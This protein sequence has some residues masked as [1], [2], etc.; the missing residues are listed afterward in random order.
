MGYGSVPPPPPGSVAAAYPVPVA[1]SR[2][3]KRLMWIILSA[4]LGAVVL[5]VMFV[6]AILFVVFGSLKSSTPYQHGVQ[7]ATHDPR[8]LVELGAPV[9]PGY[10][11]SGSINVAG[12]TGNADLT[13]PLEGT[14]HKG[15][16][17]VVAKKFEGEWTYQTLAVR[18]GDD[19]ERID[20]LQPAGASSEE[21]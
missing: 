13:I 19:T 17:Y 15:E 10:L 14:A 1:R 21:K 9:K 3:P 2:S 4:L 18:V 12:D 16:L 7:L 5:V 6:A 11:L 8:V 20:L